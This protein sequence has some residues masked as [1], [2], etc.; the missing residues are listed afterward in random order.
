MKCPKC[1]GELNPIGTSEGVELDFC[2][3]CNGILFDHGELGEFFELPEDIPELVDVW[4]G[5]RETDLSCP[6]CPGTFVEI[7]YVQGGDLKVDLCRKCGAVWLDRGEF[8][9]LEAIA[10]RMEKPRTKLMR[11]VKQV[12]KKGYQV[13]GVRRG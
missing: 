4:G 7:S 1:S 8:P 6:K 5:G 13:I 3:S 10:A 2:S 12:E 9:K 11:A